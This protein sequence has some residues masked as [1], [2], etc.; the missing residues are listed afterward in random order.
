MGKMMMML[1]KEMLGEPIFRQRP[2]F[3][4]CK[5]EKSEGCTPDDYGWEMVGSFQVIRSS[6]AE[7]LH[8]CGR[9]KRNFTTTLVMFQ[10]PL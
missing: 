4:G 8:L 7:R 6:S 9:G 10:A 5:S 2:G 3:W 1:N